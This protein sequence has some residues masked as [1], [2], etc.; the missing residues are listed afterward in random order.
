LSPDWAL[1]IAYNAAL[2]SATAALAA[3]GYRASRDQHRYR[4]IQSLQ[5]TLG[6][7]LRLADR[8]DGFRKKR[9]L[10]GYERAGSVFELV[11]TRGIPVPSTGAM[12][13]WSLLGAE[14][15][16]ESLVEAGS[17]FTCGEV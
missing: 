10:A 1:N 15:L 17:T 9:N 3:A 8:F 5:L 6:A 12:N 11:H 14:A 13:A 4:L 2:Q 16:V 7:D